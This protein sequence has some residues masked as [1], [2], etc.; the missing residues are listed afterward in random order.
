M[1]SRLGYFFGGFLVFFAG[2]VAWLAINTA[3]STM[4]G[5]QRVKMPGRAEITLPL[6][7]SALYAEG[8]DHVQCNAVGLPLRATTDDVR[9]S[10]AGYHGRKVYDADVATGGRY[11][12]ECTGE[13]PFAIAIGAGVGAWGVIAW[14]SLIPAGIGV[15]L[16]VATY[17]R[18]RRRISPIA[19][20][21]K[22]TPPIT[23]ANSSGTRASS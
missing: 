8:A 1:K 4:E 7:P 9:Y 20:G 22:Q 21:S 3:T 14:L 11:E 5:M 18:R 13:K 6:G 2:M 10:L 23:P 17:A 12:L 19:S 16:A 15:G